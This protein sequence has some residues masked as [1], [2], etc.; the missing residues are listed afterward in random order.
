MLVSDAA[1]AFLIAERARL[2]PPPD[3]R[4]VSPVQVPPLPRGYKPRLTPRTRRTT[5]AHID[6]DD[7]GIAGPRVHSASRPMP[8]LPTTYF[9]CRRSESRARFRTSSFRRRRYAIVARLDEA[10][11]RQFIR[12]LRSRASQQTPSH[13]ARVSFCPQSRVL[14]S[15]GC[16]DGSTAQRAMGTGLP[17]VDPLTDITSHRANQRAKLETHDLLRRIVTQSC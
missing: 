13:H 11:C 14:D 6:T 16:F 9:S 17:D 12:R 8:V 7:D 15:V 1:P 2:P 3:A 10:D 5:S 4:N